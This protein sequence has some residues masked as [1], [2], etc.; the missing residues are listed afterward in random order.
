LGKFPLETM[1]REHETEASSLPAWIVTRRIS[2]S[3]IDV[4]T[5]FAA[6]PFSFSSGVMHLAPE[7]AVVSGGPRGDDRGCSPES[8]INEEASA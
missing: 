5:V 2:S 3:L 4:Y 6:R 7:V 1:D 8:T